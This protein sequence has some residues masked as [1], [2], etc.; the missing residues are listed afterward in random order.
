VLVVVEVVLQAQD[1]LTIV[2]LIDL[3]VVVDSQYQQFL[4]LDMNLKLLEEVVVED[5]L[6]EEQVVELLKIIHLQPL[7]AAEE[8]RVLHHLHQEIM[9]LQQLVAVEEAADKT[10]LLMVVMVDLVLL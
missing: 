5:L 1:I 8:L 9:V 3:V 2:E 6:Q 4:W 10:L 7:L